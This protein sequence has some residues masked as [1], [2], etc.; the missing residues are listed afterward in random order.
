MDAPV[1][2]GDPA[3]LH[4]PSPR[5]VARVVFR[6]GRDSD[7]DDDAH[8]VVVAG[9]RLVTLKFRRA[10][11]APGLGDRIRVTGVLG[12]AGWACPRST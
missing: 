4:V 10:A 2:A 3:A 12:T 6:E 7:G 5:V 1:P 11:G 9:P 8:L